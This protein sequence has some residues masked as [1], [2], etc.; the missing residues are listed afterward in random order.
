[1]RVRRA[2][3]D[4]L[5]VATVMPGYDDTRTTRPDRFARARDNGNFYRTTWQAAL[6]SGADWVIITS[7][8]EWVEG[9]QIEPSVTYGNTYL[10][11][12][13]QYAAQF[14]SGAFVA[15]PAAVALPH[16]VA[17]PLP[18]VQN[19][20]SRVLLKSSQRTTTDTLRVRA[21]P[22]SSS[23][24]LGRLKAGQVVDILARTWDGR[25]LQLAYPDARRTGWVSAQ[26]IKPHTGLGRLPVY[27]DDDNPA[28]DL[29]RITQLT[30]HRDFL[31]TAC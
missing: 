22:D 13:R 2:G 28:W 9:T 24:I 14:K 15:A 26:F 4:K 16:P 21:A 5:W 8:N 29:C 1:G 31:P 10:D 6:N 17:T 18:A 11:I 30:P 23:Q 12:T 19:P 25:W 7:F 20:S 27:L 3:A